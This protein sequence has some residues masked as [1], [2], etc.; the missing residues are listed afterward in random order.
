MLP[1][2]LRVSDYSTVLK[3]EI[4]RVYGT[5]SDCSIAYAIYLD[6]EEEIIKEAFLQYSS[7]SGSIK[8]SKNRVT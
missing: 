6:I 1:Y 8:I 2:Y 7:T 4:K 3:A 5:N